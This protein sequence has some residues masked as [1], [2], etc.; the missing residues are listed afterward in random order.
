[1][2]KDF[3]EAVEFTP[4]D[5]YVHILKITNGID[6]DG[7]IIYAAATNELS[8]Y[9]DRKIEGVLEANVIWHEDPLKRNF[10]YYAESGI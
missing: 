10:L 4:N 2:E 7:V 3:K 9:P 1:M 6:N 5:L 8:G